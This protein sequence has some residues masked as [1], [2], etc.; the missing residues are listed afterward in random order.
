[1]LRSKGRFP[2]EIGRLGLL[3]LEP[4]YYAY[5]GSA[6]GPGGLRTRLGRHLHGAGRVHWHIDNLRAHAAPVEAWYSY[7]PWRREHQWSAA[8][9]SRSDAAI[10]LPGFGASDCRCDSHLF[11]FTRRPSLAD[12]RLTLRRRDL[13]ARSLFRWLAGDPIRPRGDG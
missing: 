9:R 12:F 4:G 2:V 3:H 7:G 8:L 5:V 11:F 6:L 13:P 1:M 10:P